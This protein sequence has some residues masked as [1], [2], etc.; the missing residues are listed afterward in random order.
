MK[1]NNLSV[2]P[3]LAR[4]QSLKKFFKKIDK[5]R[6]YS[7]FGS[8]YDLCENKVKRFLQLKKKNIIFTSSGFSSLLAC[9]LYI[10]NK[11][12]QK[13]YCI[14]PAFSFSASVH[15]AVLSGLE[16]FFVDISKDTLHPDVDCLK[17]VP[18]YII[19]NT[20]CI[21]LVS[22]FGYFLSADKI[23]G[24]FSK[25]KIPIVYDAA[26]SFLNLK[27]VDSLNKNIFISCSFHPTKTLPAN[28]SGLI[29]C[30]KNFKS[31]IR[32]LVNFGIMNSDRNIRQVAINGKFSEYDAAIFLA[33]Y[34]LIGSIKKYVKKNNQ[35]Y[36]ENF[37]NIKFFEL[38]NNVNRNYISNKT[39]VLSRNIFYAKKI[40]KIFFY[41]KI[42]MYLPWG[43]KL[44]CHEKPFKQYKKT[45]LNVSERIIR[46]YF[47]LPNY[48][49]IS[50]KKI[51]HYCRILT[52]V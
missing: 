44:I 3:Y 39:L 10:K 9:L 40:K 28:E 15:S 12:K 16:P 48:Y 33:N 37:K 29:I 47:F 21:M 36:R 23:N 14:I 4:F 18:N 7:N 24:I 1:T 6:V 43:K 35:I 19:K 25:F 2:Y 51:F 17:S 52:K 50:K 13:K 45:K 42:F 32:S 34:N 5:N 49:S 22:P 26:D 8:L 11:N 31:E 38:F 27:S 41:K 30:H 46:T 20:A